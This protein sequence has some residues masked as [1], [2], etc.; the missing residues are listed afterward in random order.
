VYAVSRPF[1]EPVAAYINTIALV[2]DGFEDPTNIIRHFKDY[3]YNVGFANSSKAAVRPAGFAPMIIA[4]S[5]FTEVSSQLL[6]NIIVLH[7]SM[8]I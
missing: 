8:G 3:W 4:V 2:Y 7:K 5:C 1:Q 6:T